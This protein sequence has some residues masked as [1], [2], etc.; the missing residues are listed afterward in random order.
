MVARAEGVCSEEAA[1][2]FFFSFPFSSL[3]NWDFSQRHVENPEQAKDIKDIGAGE[4]YV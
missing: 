2:R 3:L 4:V 1:T